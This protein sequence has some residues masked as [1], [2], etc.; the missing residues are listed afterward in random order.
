MYFALS[1]SYNKLITLVFFFCYL[2]SP[3]SWFDLDTL[4]KV[5]LHHNVSTHSANVSQKNWSWYSG[6][7][8]RLFT[9]PLMISHSSYS[10]YRFYQIRSDM[11]WWK[12]VV[13][14]KVGTF[15]VWLLT[16]CQKWARIT[17]QIA[18]LIMGEFKIKAGDEER[19]KWKLMCKFG[20]VFSSP[21]GF[22]IGLKSWSH[23]LG[24]DR[25]DFRL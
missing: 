23:D 14:L 9:A 11:R 10:P 22:K 15:V 2:F 12:L 13:S 20:T 1:A 3:Y 24:D 18:L 17:T 5:N 19:Q 25:E 7:Q 16:P 21:K 4:C 6:G 8:H